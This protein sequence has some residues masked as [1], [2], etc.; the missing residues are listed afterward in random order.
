[1]TFFPVRIEAR[2]RW[3]RVRRIAEDCSEVRHHGLASMLKCEEICNANASA[4][5]LD[6]SP[7]RFGHARMLFSFLFDLCFCSC[8]FRGPLS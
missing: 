5:V 7:G 4:V 1:M 8:S 3:S 6:R 2:W